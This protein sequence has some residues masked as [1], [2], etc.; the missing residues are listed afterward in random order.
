LTQ[1]PLRR[2]QFQP[3][4]NIKLAAVVRV[5]TG[6]TGDC[7]FDLAY[8]RE[9]APAIR[10]TVDETRHITPRRKRQ[11]MTALFVCDSQIATSLLPLGPV[12]W[13]WSPTLFS[14]LRQNMSKFVPKCAIDFRGVLYQPRVQRN[15][16]VAIIS[17][18][19]G[20][21]ETGIPFDAKFGCD[22]FRA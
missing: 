12:R 11:G 16:F 3:K 20:G 1:T 6:E 19:S 14:E 7:A 9:I 17:A 2:Q 15:Q 22:P 4:P 21:F 5:A 18:A 13:N 10:A 8:A